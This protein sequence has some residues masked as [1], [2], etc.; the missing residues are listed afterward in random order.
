M[1]RELQFRLA[2]MEHTLRILLDELDT[3][4][5]LE[6]S[7]VIERLEQFE[8][9]SRTLSH[10]LVGAVHRLRGKLADSGRVQVHASRS[11]AQSYTGGYARR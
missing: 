4:G 1:D 6:R 3:K 5:A 2:A 7:A 9:S 10:E 8:Q 11:S